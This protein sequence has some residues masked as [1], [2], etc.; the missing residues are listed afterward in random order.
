MSFPALLAGATE[1]PGSPGFF[2]ARLFVAWRAVPSCGAA[3]ARK[4]CAR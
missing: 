2:F 1:K 3:V 4:T